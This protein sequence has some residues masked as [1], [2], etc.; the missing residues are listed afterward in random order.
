MVA[1]GVTPTSLDQISLKRLPFSPLRQ[2]FDGVCFGRPS[3]RP[4][5]LTERTLLSFGARVADTVEVWKRSGGITQRDA[6]EGNGTCEV[7]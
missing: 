2:L 7:V 5:R 3:T 4:P 6:F 1:H